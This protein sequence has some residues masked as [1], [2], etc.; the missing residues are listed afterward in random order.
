MGH[1]TLFMLFMDHC[2]RNGEMGDIPR[3][4]LSPALICHTNQSN[5]YL[6]NFDSELY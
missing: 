4:D 6:H 2:P 3:S 1:I 5:E